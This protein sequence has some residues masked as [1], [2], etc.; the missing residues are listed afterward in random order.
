MMS[1][2][3]LMAN[4]AAS[5][6]SSM[7]RV[8]PPP[9]LLLAAAL[10]LAALV[11]IPWA[12]QAQSDDTK[13]KG[14]TAQVVDGGVLLAWN[15]PT[16]DTASVDGYEI[17]RRRPF[18][19]EDTFAILVPD[20]GSAAT[21]YTDATAT[22]PGVRYT[23]RVK[24]LRGSLKSAWSNY[25]YA[26]VPRETDSTLISEPTATPM[27]TPAPDPRALAPSGLEVALVDGRV[28]LTWT[29][30]AEDP[31]SVTGYEVLRR[32]PNRD[33]IGD[34]PVSMSTGSTGTRYVD[35]TAN[36]AGEGYTYRVKALRGSEKSARS[37]Y[38]RIDLPGDYEP[39]GSRPDPANLAPTGLTAEAD[40][41]GVDLA[42]DRPASDSDT[43]TGYAMERAQGEGDFSQLVADTG[44]TNT[45]Y[46]D[47]TAVAGTAYRYRVAA[48]R[49]TDRSQW[50]SEVPVTPEPPGLTVGTLS[51][52]LLGYSES[53][54]IGSL[55]PNEVSIEDAQFRVTS[56]A[57]WS[58][59]P[60]L[61]VLLTGGDAAT[62]RAL[63]QRNLPSLSHEYMLVIGTVEFSL[64]DAVLAHSEPTEPGDPYEG[65]VAVTWSAGQAALNA[66]ETVSFA[67]ERRDRPDPA[68][69]AP[70]GLSASETANGV[71]LSWTAPISGSDTV[72][73]YAIE[74]AQGDGDFSHLTADTGSAGTS[75]TDTTAA[76]G[77]TYRYRTAALRGADRSQWSGEASVTLE[78][79]VLPTV[80]WKDLEEVWSTTMTVD[81]SQY[82]DKGYLIDS[83]GTLDDRTLTWR[84]HDL[85]VRKLYF[86]A[87]SSTLYLSVT[88]GTFAGDRDWSKE[89]HSAADPAYLLRL[90]DRMFRV[91][92]SKVRWVSFV[93][94]NGNY[95]ADVSHKWAVDGLGWSAGDTVPVSIA[96]VKQIGAADLAP[97]G[98]SAA[99]IN[100][101]VTLGWDVPREASN[102]VTGYRIERSGAGSDTWVSVADTDSTET[103]HTDSMAHPNR[104][105][106]YRV[107]SRRGN[108][109]SQPSPEVSVTLTVAPHRLAP[110]NLS[111]EVLP[112]D[113]PGEAG[114]IILRWNQPEIDPDSVDG[115]VIWRAQGDADF[116]ALT[117][118]TG[119]A[120]TTYTDATATTSGQT[121]AYRVLARRGEAVSSPS[122]AHSVDLPGLQFTGDPQFSTQSVD[123]TRNATGRPT[124]SGTAAVGQT[125][126][127]N[128]SGIGDPE[129]LGTFSY[130]WIATRN[131]GARTAQPYLIHNNSGNP[132]TGTS[133]TVRQADIGSGIAVRV[134]F[135]D[136]ANNDEAVISERTRRV[137]NSELSGQGFTASQLHSNNDSPN[138]I[139][140]DG[141]TMWVLDSAK[142]KVFA[143]RLSDRQR[144]TSKEFNLHS[145]HE[146][147]GMLTSDGNVMWILAN[148]SGFG[149][150]HIFAYS[151]S[152]GTRQPGREIAVAWFIDH[153][154]WGIAA[155]AARNRM[156][157]LAPSN[158]PGRA[159]VE[160]FNRRLFAFDLTTGA[161]RPQPTFDPLSDGVVAWELS[162]LLV[163]G[164][165]VWISN[166]VDGIEAI[167][168]FSFSRGGAATPGRDVFLLPNH[169]SPGTFT[170][171]G[172]TM[173]V[174]DHDEISIRAYSIPSGSGYPSDRGVLPLIK[175]AQVEPMSDRVRV[176]L[177][178]DTL[179]W[180]ETWEDAFI[181][182]IRDTWTGVG[183]S[184][185]VGRLGAPPPAQFERVINHLAGGTEYDLWFE[186]YE[187]YRIPTNSD[188][189]GRV[190]TTGSK[191]LRDL[192]D[193]RTLPK[194]Q[195]YQ[196]S[197]LPKDMW[198]DGTTIWVTHGISSSDKI[199]AYNQSD[200]SRDPSKDITTADA[201]EG[202]IG[203]RAE[204]LWSNGTTMWV[205]ASDQRKVMA[206]D[207]T[208]GNFGVRVPEKDIPLAAENYD[209]TGVASDGFFFWVANQGNPDDP[210]GYRL[211]AYQASTKERAGPQDIQ[212]DVVPDFPGDFPGGNFRPKGLME[213][214]TEMRVAQPYGNRLWGYDTT[215]HKR[216][217]G[218][219]VHLHHSNGNAWGIFGEY[220]LSQSYD[221]LWVLDSSG[222]IFRYKVKNFDR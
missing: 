76:A 137:P 217:P 54:G 110:R 45:S 52:D 29:A 119:S 172:N 42:W 219:D 127:V 9:F 161:Y 212:L 89:N 218:K 13:P 16:Q 91:A 170:I 120:E 124:I 43:V 145:D 176:R 167:R 144:Q 115:Y 73:G 143:Y 99:A 148:E 123:T 149:Q 83:L 117:L 78:E 82:G 198:M 26:D 60:G 180:P 130:Q 179:A 193:V 178:F 90:G 185:N 57:S 159:E 5:S 106:A 100:D 177:E 84:G 163:S 80:R 210:Y 98:L 7:A 221:R 135:A 62:D 12:V 118:D 192:I 92:D 211:F 28:T 24:A 95:V 25:A 153:N 183:S 108:E 150:Q 14:L 65:A 56:V 51:G 104:S 31:A 133:Y 216:R 138:G 205:V 201:S 27:P 152:D 194:P 165:T 38:A 131:A 22:E 213:T 20:T 18:N 59:A 181:F 168:A 184:L 1:T 81:A 10:L 199:Y 71:A 142:R 196:Y 2:R 171:H 93:D 88:T 125:L 187:N 55:R 186:F 79:V 96:R 109:L 204:G 44:S 121:Y 156:W 39:P 174:L 48:L 222:K 53:D 141:T 41:G 35:E 87:G 173:W 101:S 103:T 68:L 207:M 190:T 114:G 107:S 112:G 214:A 197:W 102:E 129:G 36:E 47:A 132:Y 19:G 157:V 105:Y 69:L 49:G 206:F 94:I 113:S 195:D 160:H 74:R 15:A 21:S 147:P 208:S 6:I 30:P 128:T 139:W 75:H 77:T 72:T 169:V 140:T 126:T 191:P 154:I 136:G 175:V 8:Y 23:Y 215:V 146:D 50:S 46:A 67:L 164:D 200:L 166:S 111:A 182:K 188:Y 17:L 70:S 203:I 158:E 4:L 116:A 220:M 86:H 33:A 61:V 63:S 3:N 155:D 37:S 40:D 34:F 202:I 58:A 189:S 151:L 162:H 134:S 64:D 32:D 85:T 97:T 209:P 11:V 66:G 122:G